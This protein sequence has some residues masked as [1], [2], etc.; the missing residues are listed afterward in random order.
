MLR[1]H[2]VLLRLQGLERASE[3]QSVAVPGA[4]ALAEGQAEAWEVIGGVGML[5]SGTSPYFLH[6][7]LRVRETE[8][9]A[10]GLAIEE[11]A[12]PVDRAGGDKTEHR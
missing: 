4:A 1:G 11:S 7:Q 6:V 8:R 3:A 2:P 12:L 10:T 9:K 5:G